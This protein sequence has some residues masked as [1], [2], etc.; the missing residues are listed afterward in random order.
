M[1]LVLCLSFHFSALS[2]SPSLCSDGFQ[3]P[4]LSAV[5]H[6]DLQSALLFLFAGKAFAVVLISATTDKQ[7]CVLGF[8]CPNELPPTQPPNGERGPGKAGCWCGGKEEIDFTVK[9]PTDVLYCPLLA[10]SSPSCLGHE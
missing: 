7:W 4:L 5:G 2:P 1:D 8:L 6:G 3:L 10:C 9:G